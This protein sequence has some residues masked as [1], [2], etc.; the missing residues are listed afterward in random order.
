MALVHEYMASKSNSEIQQF[1]KTEQSWNKAECG[2]TRLHNAVRKN[3]P[4]KARSIEGWNKLP[5]N[6]RPAISSESFRKSL[7]GHEE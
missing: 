5:V 3:R 7:K 4:E 1:G 6:V 2:R